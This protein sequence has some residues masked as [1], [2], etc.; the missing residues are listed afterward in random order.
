MERLTFTC[1]HCRARVEV[2]DETVGKEPKCPNCGASLAIPSPEDNSTRQTSQGFAQLVLNEMLYITSY[3]A[4]NCID[5]E[6]CSRSEQLLIS[7]AVGHIF[8]ALVFARLKRRNAGQFYDALTKQ[9]QEAVPRLFGKPAGGFFSNLIHGRRRAK[10]LALS[11]VRR[12]EGMLL[13]QRTGEVREPLVREIFNKFNQ[14]KVG[15]VAA[16]YI[17]GPCRPREITDALLKHYEMTCQLLAGITG[18]P[19]NNRTD[20]G[21]R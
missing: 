11:T 7:S 10:D 16:F 6:K 18:Q 8:V 1:G 9:F 13:K 21:E 3:C 17:G 2:A 4:H 19:S 15:E 12:F 5:P 14:G 20:T